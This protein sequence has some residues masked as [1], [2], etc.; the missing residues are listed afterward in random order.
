MTIGPRSH[1]EREDKEA[2][3]IHS[4]LEGQKLERLSP[5][6]IVVAK[7]SPWF[8][9]RAERKFGYNYYRDL[10]VSMT[11]NTFF[12]GSVVLILTSLPRRIRTQSCCR[13]DPQLTTK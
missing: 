3:T 10:T 9:A 8:G 12:L 7:I 13:P 4:V 2:S 5:F 6:V 1:H 11:C